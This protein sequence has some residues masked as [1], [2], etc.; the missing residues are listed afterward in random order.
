MDI[1]LRLPK[2]LEEKLLDVVCHSG[3][4]TEAFVLDAIADKLLESEANQNGSKQSLDS[5]KEELA[6]CVALHPQV[7]GDIDDSRDRIYRD[8]DE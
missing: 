4:S 5:W 2:F 3:K 7:E 1:R 8:S 6:M